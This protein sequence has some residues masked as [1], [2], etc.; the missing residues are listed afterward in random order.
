MTRAHLT[1][2]R[3]IRALVASVL[4]GSVALPAAA[5]AAGNR[6]S[7]DSA[8]AAP[9]H[10]ACLERALRTD[11]RSYL[12]ARGKA[13][14]IS[15]AGLSVRFPGARGT[16]DVAAGTTRVGGKQP[17]RPSAVWQI[18]SNTKAFTSVILLQLE[19]EH[20]LSIDD[21][22]GKWLPRYQRWSDVTIKRLLNMTSGIPTYDTTLP[23]LHAYAAHP[24]RNFTPRA[25]VR[26]AAP[27][28]PTTGYS[29]SNTNYVLGEMIIEKA[30]HHSYRHELRARI[31]RPLHLRSLYYRSDTYPRSVTRR[32]PAG[33][34]FNKETPGFSSLMGRDVSRAT[35]SW[36]RG[37][38]GI[39][40]TT[41]AMTVW[42]HAL[43]GGRL[44]PAQQEKELLSL[45][46]VKTG[47]PIKHTTPSDPQGF[48]LGTA[49]LTTPQ[50]GRIWFYEGETL[51][52]RTL[53][54]YLP[55]S[56]VI[57]AM[58]LNSQ[59]T[60]DQI[61]NLAI[62]VYNTLKSNGLLRPPG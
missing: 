57:V 62:S 54:M 59:P 37:A 12:K 52:F 29:Y 26:Y 25:L 35:L 9:C 3:T 51:G 16:I 17:V 56:G 19:A 44:L 27:G 4:I 23:F 14:H 33:Y 21:T 61:G 24:H 31:I 47:K 58:G 6:I 22:L 40:A 50:T 28:T 41:R 55:K 39:I 8:T 13:E 48:A 5:T 7:A 43:Y 10:R 38:G 45:V 1:G 30:T 2:V 46:S 11:L 42:E 20:R 53:H 32:E 15:A 60:V 18:G 36:A 49:Q 34:F